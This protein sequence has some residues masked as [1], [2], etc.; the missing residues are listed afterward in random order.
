MEIYNLISSGKQKYTT[1]HNNDYNINS[2]PLPSR[3]SLGQWEPFIFSPQ[4]QRFCL[5]KHVLSLGRTWLCLLSLVGSV[6]PLRV[7]HEVMQHENRVSDQF[8]DPPNPLTSD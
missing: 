7:T 2:P 3:P 4:V 6:P 1:N 5:L 8:T